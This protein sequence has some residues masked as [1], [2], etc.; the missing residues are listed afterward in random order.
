MTKTLNDKLLVR[1]MDN[2]KIK[3]ENKYNS[4]SAIAKDL[5]IDYFQ[6]RQVYLQSTKKQVKK[7]QPFI[8]QLCEKII[9]ID[10]P[11]YYNINL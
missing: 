8:K 11:E 7:V 3:S 5:N 2:D 10:N 6:L 4:L 9:I 1:I